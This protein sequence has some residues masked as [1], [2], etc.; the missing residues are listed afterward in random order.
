MSS[1]APGAEIRYTLEPLDYKRYYAYLYSRQLP[2]WAQII[3]PSCLML[4]ALYML[5]RGQNPL[6]Y[7]IVNMCLV[8]CVLFLWVRRIAL[9]T[10]KL[11]ENSTERLLR[12]TPAG[13]QQ[14][15]DAETETVLWVDIRDIV[16]TKEYLYFFVSEN[17]AFVAPVRAFP[18]PQA[19]QEF[20]RL[21]GELRAVY[22]ERPL[23]AENSTTDG[24]GDKPSEQP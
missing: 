11:P 7:P 1:Q 15:V 13:I 4:P 8:G 9:R 6:H 16:R 23:P 14:T 2:V 12:L 20:Y 21:A 10:P 24:S 22:K 3:L 19:A 17:T 18:S 5:I